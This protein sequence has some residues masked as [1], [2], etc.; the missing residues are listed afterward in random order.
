MNTERLHYLYG[1]L[2]ENA[3]TPAELAE[4]QAYLGNPAS[5]EEADPMMDEIWS[6][7]SQ[8]ELPDFDREEADRFFSVLTQQQRR[9]RTVFY[10]SLM[11]AASVL[12]VCLSVYLL[13]YN[14]ME[15]TQA[16][17]GATAGK[18]MQDIMPGGNK[19]ILTLGDGSTV[20]LDTAQ[21]GELAQ[22]EGATVHKLKNGQL[23]YAAVD[24]KSAGEK[25]Q[26]NT[27]TVPK[28]GEYTI[29]LA[30]GTRVFMN[31]A[32]S[33]SYPT[34]FTGRNRLVKLAGEA[35]FEVTKHATEPFIV[36]VG[37]RQRIEVLGTNFNVQ[38]YADE[39]AM[40]TTLLEGSVR[41]SYESHTVILKPGQIASAIN[42]SLQISQADE[43]EVMAWRN[44]IFIF[45]NENIVSLMKRVSRW[46]NVEVVFKGDMS[47]VNFI[48]SYSRTR[49][50]F[51]LLKTIELTGKVSFLVQDGNVT[52]I[53]KTTH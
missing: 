38:A 15:H 46:Y 44:G 37:N 32:S 18:L 22:Q 17:D 9:K 52:V 33:L 28:G 12:A 25:Q 27:I 4:L 50:L 39:P 6:L 23:A 26:F 31:A 21:N 40:H 24:G 36:E 11:V 19:A 35:Y 20:V 49:S 53:E 42:N 34:R 41:L 8:Q 16:T 48:G 13:R 47:G 10:R 30:D 2:Q 3:C 43:D 29:T 51:N 45:N 5:R 7:L 1:R 14:S